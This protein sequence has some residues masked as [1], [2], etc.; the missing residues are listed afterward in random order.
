MSVLKKII[1]NFLTDVY[2]FKRILFIPENVELKKIRTNLERS[3]GILS[4]LPF[5]VSRKIFSSKFSII[6]W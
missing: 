5:N 4:N 1:L 6:L 3:F 2:F